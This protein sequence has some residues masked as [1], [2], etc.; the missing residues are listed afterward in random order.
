MDF[1]LKV[2]FPELNEFQLRMLERFLLEAYEKG[3]HDA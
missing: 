3:K 2:W 1:H